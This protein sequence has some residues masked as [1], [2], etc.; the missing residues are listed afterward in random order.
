MKASH[1]PFVNSA[2]DA[3]LVAQFYEDSSIVRVSVDAK[4]SVIGA[5]PSKIRRWVDPAMDSFH[6]PWP[7]VSSGLRGVFEAIE[8]H[9]EMGSREFQERPKAVTVQAFVYGLLDKCKALNPSWLSVPQLPVPKELNRNSLNKELARAT[10]RWRTERGFSGEFVLPVIVTHD[11][12]VHYKAKRTAVL[13]QAVACRDLSS[14]EGFWLVHSAL[15]D[16]SGSTTNE[17]KRFPGL[18]AL[19]E[20]LR[21]G[22]LGSGFVVGGPY[23]G[24]NLVLWARGLIEYPAIGVGSGF[25]YFIPGGPLKPGN[26]KAAVAPLRRLVI[27]TVALQGWLEEAERAQQRGGKAAQEFEQ[28]RKLVPQLMRN[29]EAAKRQVAETYHAWISKLEQAP[30]AGRALALYQD[31]SEAYVVGKG[32]KTA[33]PRDEKVT[34]P[35]RIA[36]QLMMSCL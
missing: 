19:H 9:E 5:L 7:P 30:E 27:A 34:R 1:I 12:L 2:Q 31:L 22:K 32:L 21:K 13:K 8:G 10:G 23:W 26:T 18:I 16:Q 20:E 14:A 17:K 28:L 29:K 11:D 25:Q 36:Q 15:D 33:L 4:D 35:E 6:N 24:M 3:K